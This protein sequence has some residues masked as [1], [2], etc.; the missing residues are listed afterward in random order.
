MLRIAVILL[1]SAQSLSAQKMFPSAAIA[2]AVDTLYEEIKTR[3]PYPSTSE[4]LAALEAALTRVRSA[5]DGTVSGRDSIPYYEFVGLVAPLQEATKCGHLILQPYLDTAGTR[6]IMQRIFPLSMVPLETGEYVL[7][8]AVETDT[9]SLPA[10]TIVVAVNGRETDALLREISPFSGINDEGNEWA[11]LYK[12]ARNPMHLYQRYYGPQDSVV[13][14][15]AEEWGTERDYVIHPRITEYVN[16]RKDKT[17]IANT[18]SFELSED[19]KI[20]TLTIRKFSDYQFTD[21]NYFKFI[22][23]V[24]DTLNANG[25]PALIIDIRDNGGGRRSRITELYRYLTDE[26]FLF[27]AKAR[28]TGPA[29]A[30]PGENEKNTR[31]RE[32]GAVSRRDR[33][34]QRY[35]TKPIRPVR[36]KRL[37]DGKVV[38]LINELSFSASG[39][40]ARMV[41][42]YGRGELVGAVS[43]ASAGVMYGSS[44]RGKPILIGPAR[45]F[46]LKVNNIGLYPRYPLPGNVTPDHLVRPT[47]AGIRAGRDEQMERALE[48]IA[49]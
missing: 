12:T 20:G 38:V 41:Q 31:R 10:G 11:L 2:G 40:F 15:V 30:A 32:A 29:R 24:F 39:L 26:K 42:G 8:S 44:Y 23:A 48:I 21:G 27:T 1:F 45:D 19:R 47:L 17:P 25:V 9:A 4:G 5:V 16:P 34:I 36:K 46:Q 35:V 18:L 22:R 6:A 37:Y 13:I 3:H 49:Q 43:G 33:R 28:M 7:L 14:T